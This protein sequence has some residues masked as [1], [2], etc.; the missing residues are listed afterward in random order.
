MARWIRLDTTFDSSE[1]LFVLS[2]ES[3]LAWV[4]MLCYVKEAGTAGKAK[5]LSHIVAAKRWSL[6]SES[7][8]K[9]EQAAITHGAVKIV[10][11]SWLVVKWDQYQ[12]TDTTNA[13][14]QRRFKSKNKVT[15]GNG[16]TTKDNNVTTVTNRDRCR[17]TETGTETSKEK[18]TPNGVSQK[19]ERKRFVPPTPGEVESYMRLRGWSDPAFMAQKFIDHY[20]ANGWRRG[21]GEGIKIDSWQACVRTWENKRKDATHA[22][23]GA[24]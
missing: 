1:W 8:E 23:W 20:E 3:Q 16:V 22:N 9:L 7:V 4:K 18:E 24:M 12:T 13:E 19:K 10:G 14:R 2:P 6:G 5:R 21:K 15:A 17:V 11:D